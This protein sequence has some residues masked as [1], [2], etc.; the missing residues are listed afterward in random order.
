MSNSDTE[1]HKQIKSIDSWMEGDML[2]LREQDKIQIRSIP[3]R[4]TEDN[5]YAALCGPRVDLLNYYFEYLYAQLKANDHYQL[6]VFFSVT[7]DALLEF[8][9]KR[10]ADISVNAAKSATDSELERK[11]LVI[12]DC[13]AMAKSEWDLLARLLIDFPGANC[14]LLIICEE[15]FNQEVDAF[16]KLLGSRL[17]RCYCN[18]P[19]PRELVGFLDASAMMPYH[20][21]NK[22]KLAALGITGADLEVDLSI[23]RSD[24]SG[25]DFSTEVEGEKKFNKLLFFTFTLILFIAF[26]V[27]YQLNQKN[28]PDFEAVEETIAPDHDASV[29]VHEEQDM[30]PEESL[31]YVSDPVIKD[32]IDDASLS[33]EG[34]IAGQAIDLSTETEDLSDSI[35]KDSNTNDLSNEVYFEEQSATVEEDTLSPIIADAISLPNNPSEIEQV[36]EEPVVDQPQNKFDYSIDTSV[37]YLQHAALSSQAAA[38]TAISEVFTDFSSAFPLPQFSQKK[39]WHMVFSGPYATRADAMNVAKEN[40]V[41][42]DVVIVRGEYIVSRVPS[43]VEDDGR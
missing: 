6:E 21:H 16:C 19:D 1:D 39:L 11:I 30:L 33:S 35:V 10:L 5:P 42:A 37:Y 23:G 22:K 12:S 14:G 29:L 32:E 20:S 41:T 26:G 34:N 27:A 25:E 17:T 8:Y 9:N 18:F 4:L 36:L 24:E 40:G 43:E 28:E 31:D 13:T 3:A 38:K 7:T 15:P 2:F